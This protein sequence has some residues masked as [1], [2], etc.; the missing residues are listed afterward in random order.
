M[1]SCTIYYYLSLPFFLFSRQRD[2]VSI[3]EFSTKA[4]ITFIVR[5][6]TFILFIRYDLRT[7]SILSSVKWHTNTRTHTNIIFCII[8][9]IEELKIHLLQQNEKNQITWNKQVSLICSAIKLISGTQ[10][11]NFYF[12]SHPYRSS[13]TIVMWHHFILLF[14]LD[15][16]YSPDLCRKFFNW[17][18]FSTITPSLI[19]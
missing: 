6:N 18:V 15:F 9:I 7:E 19:N 13:T 17:I 5:F 2:Y 10:N 3:F 16:Y 12:I 4:M 14:K 1:H 11:N 8:I